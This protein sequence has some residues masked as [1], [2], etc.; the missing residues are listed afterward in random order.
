MPAFTAKP[1][2]TWNIIYKQLNPYIQRLNGA[3]GYQRLIDDILS[4]FTYEEYISDKSLD[5][6]YLLG[7]SLQRREF[8]KNNDQEEKK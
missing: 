4:K 7:Y 6:K 3:E 2:S 1:Y 5:G 8:N